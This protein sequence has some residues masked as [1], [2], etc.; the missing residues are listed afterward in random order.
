M[1]PWKLQQPFTAIV[2]WQKTKEMWVTFAHLFHTHTHT[3]MTSPWNKSLN[4]THT[5][6]HIQFVISPR[7]SN[8]QHFMNEIIKCIGIQGVVG[9]EKQFYFSL[10]LFLASFGIIYPWFTHM[11]LHRALFWICR[12]ENVHF[13]WFLFKSVWTHTTE[14]CWYKLHLGCINNVKFKF[15]LF[16]C[17]SHKAMYTD[18]Y[19][20]IYI[21]I[22]IYI[23]LKRSNV[24]YRLIRMFLL[25]FDILSHYELSYGKEMQ[26]QLLNCSFFGWTI[27]LAV[28]ITDGSIHENK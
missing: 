14:L 26:I 21:Y 12:M 16:Q 28:F 6:T 25:L 20:Y 23:W 11:L 24:L 7:I 13:L 9:K 1:L 19:T 15:W 10:A 8:S 18:I 2:I 22:Y 27:A 17:I 4:H 3:E 5:H